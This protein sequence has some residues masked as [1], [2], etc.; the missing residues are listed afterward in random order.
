[1]ATPQGGTVVG[2]SATISQAPGTTTITQTSQRAAIDWQSFNLGSKARV[3][4][5]QPNAQAIALNRV[6]ANN[7]SIIAGR[8]DANGRIVLVNQDGVVFTPGSE[9]NAES[10]V[11]S[12][13][14]IS[15]KNFMAGKL[16]FDQQPKPG[17]RIVNDGRITMKQAGLAA[18]VAPEVINRG[19]ITAQLGHVVLAG[20]SAFTLNL[21]GDGL[22]SINVTQAV[23]QIDLGGRKVTALVTNEGT[24]IA[25]GG[26]ITLTARAVDGL[27]QQLLDVGGTLR[28]DSVGRQPGA[29]TIQGVGG[30][31]Q[32]AGQLLARGETPGSSGGTIAVDATGN[33]SVASTA[34]IDASGP[35]GGGVVALGTDA[36]RALQGPSDTTAPKAARVA[37][38]QGAT[39]SADAT[40]NGN[41]G[42]ITVLSRDRTTAAGTIS[43]QG[44]GNGDGGL[45]EIS[46]DGVISLSGTD[47]TFAPS[48][49]NG[50]ILLDPQ[51]LIVTSSSGTPSAG[52]T[53]TSGTLTVGTDSSTS[54]YID[55]S[56]LDSQ[57]G[58]VE[59]SA[60][61][62]ISIVSAISSSSIST[63]AMN[64]GGDI[65][66]AAPV[67]LT[68][69]SIEATANGTIEV[70]GALGASSISLLDT[71]SSPTNKIDINANIDAPTLSLDAGS[72]TIANA[73]SGYVTASTLDAAA[74]LVALTGSNSITTLG[75][76]N[77]G[78][79]T[80]DDNAPLTIAG[81]FNATDASITD[82][83]SL[84]IASAVSAIGSLGL[85][86]SDIGINASLDATTLS[87]DA[88]SGTIA[89]AGSGYVTAS[90]LDAAAS[91]VALTGSNSIT[92]LGSVN[93][94]NLTLDDNAPLT[95]AGSFNATDASITDTGSLD[96]ASAVSAIGSL[97]LSAS[98]IGINASLDA[99]TLSLDAKGGTITNAGS[100]SG[101]V[102]GY[103]TASTLDA[104]ASLVA[105]TGSNSI[106]T[107]GSVNVGTLTLD[108]NAPLTIAGSFTATSASLTDTGSL[109]ITGSFNATAA[110][111]AAPDIRINANIDAQTLSLDASGGTISNAGSV[112][113]YVTASVLDATASVLTLAGTGSSSLNNSI[114][115]LGSINV[116]S[117]AL[118]DEAALTIAAPFNATVASL[119]APDI[120]INASLDAQTLSLDASGG[121]ISNAGSGSVSGYVTA[122]TL[123]ATASVLTLAG[124]GSSSLNNSIDTLGS[125][126][127][128]S[129]ALDDETALTIAAPFNVTVASLAAPDI[130]INANIDAQTLSLDASG[131]TISNAGS[132][133]GYVTASTL[134]ATASVLTLVGTGNSSLNNAITTLGS[135]NVGSLALDDETALTI[136]APF[137]ATVASL[138]AP[139]IR[140]N[141]NIDAQTL[142]LD[143]SGGT[144][145]NAG[146]VSGYVTASVLDA[147]ASVLTLAG[148]G[149]SSLNNAIATLG[150]INV[151]S[152]AL[153]DETALTI[154][155]PFNATVASLAAPD[156][157]INANIDA[158]T[159]SLDASGGTISNAGSVSGYVTAS[160]LDATA[161]VLTLAGTGSSSLNNA[162]DTLGSINVGSLAL[163]DETALT[164]AGTVSVATHGQVA[165]I[166]RGLDDT[167]GATFLAPDGTIE[168]APLG[169][170]TIAGIL[171]L[172]GTSAGNVNV[173]TNFVT[174]LADSGAALLDLGTA[175][176]GPGTLAGGVI[177][178]GN[179]P[180]F[181][182]TLMVEASG[183]IVNDGLL[184]VGNITVM[185]S[186]F[187]GSGAVTADSLAGSV[188][189]F[190]SLQNRGNSIKVITSLSAGSSID[191]ADSQPL[192]IAGTLSV[193][194]GG[195]IVLSANGMD[196]AGGTILAN[197]GA[198]TLAPLGFD[199]IALGGTSTTALDL[200]NQLLNA[201][202]A[203]SLQIGTVQTG[204]IENDGSISLSIPNI[205]MDA[206]TIN[207]NQPFLA[208]HSSLIVQAGGE[209]TGNGGITVAALGAAASLV[210]LTGSNAITTLGSIS[211]GSFTLDDNAPLTIAGPFTATNASITN[212]GSLDITGSFNATDASL[213]AS[214]IRINANLDATT[215]SLD[216]N[217]GTI[218]NAGSGSVSGY[219][220]A[221]N[222]DATAS[223]VAL[224]GSNSITTLGSI[225]AGSFTLDDNAPLT[226]A[227]SF[228]AT[229]ASLS[230]SD[231]RINAN[232]D[233]TTLSLDANG[234]TITNAGS[235]SGYVTA[236]NLDATAS[237]VALTG[238]NS[239]TT[240]GS[241]NVGNLT[242]DDNAPLTIA[243]SFNATDA[244]IT[245]TGSL[246]IA[247]AV[248]AIG[249]LGLSASDIGIN[250]SLDATTLSLDAK[251]GT[252]TNA[253]SG[254]V[255]G[256]V[257]AS[258]LDATA[259]LVALTGSNAITTL[260]S[261]SAGSF[262][263]D[264]NAPLTIAGSFNAT[265][266]SLAASDIRINANLDAT[267]LSLDANGGT[268]TNAGSVSGY[269]TASNLDATAS[270]V[271]LT[272]SNA[273]TTLGSISAGSFTL[274]DN[275]P[276]T[277]TGSFNAT[278][279][280]LSASDI[281]INANLDATT[282]SL[283]A[284]A[285][286]IANAGSG[287][288]NATTLDAVASLVALTGS[289][290]ITTLGNVSAG[291]FTL[292]D[293]V[294]LTVAGPF[295]ATSASLTDTSAG[296]F[297]IAGQVSLASFLALSATSGS[298]TSSGTGSI[299]APTL[300][301]AAS[302]V[303]LTGSN[304]VTTLGSINVGTLTLDDE[305]AA[306]T[307]AG[308][309]NVTDARLTDTGSLDIASAVSAIGSLGLAASNIGINASLD[310]TIL[311]L[312][313]GSGTIANAG[314]G[315]VNATTLDA[316]AS[317][318]AL[319]GSNAITTLGSINVGN[320]TL[321]DNAPLTIAG[322]FNATSASLTDTSAGG[323]DIAGQVS[324]ASLLALSATG[325]SITSSGTGSISA[326]TLDATASL[327]ALTG[328]NSITTLGSINVGSF[329]LDDN[330]PLTIAGPFT[331][332][333]ASLTDTSAG[334][335]D[336]AAQVSL[337]S[338][339]ALS[340]TS[341]SITS[342]GTG[343]I[344][345]PTLDAAA[346]LVALTG[347]NSITTLGSINV[348]TLTLDDEAAALTIAG[349]LVAQ[350]AA[351]SA[352]DLTIPGVILVDGAL[353]LATS[354]TISE[355]GTIDPT[356]LQIAGARDVLLTGSNTI[357]ALGSVSVPLGNLALVDQVPLTVNGPVYAL[358]ISLDSPAMYIP[359]AINTPGTLGLGY[360]PIS[361]NGPIT[362]AT[363]TSNSAV[364]G[365]V[366]L[367][368]TENV[369]GTL[370]GFDAAGHLFALTDAT[371]LTV[372][373]PVSAKAL[374]ITATGQITLDGADGGSFAI[375]GQFL[376]TYVYNGLS[377]RNGID[378]VLQVI[379]N[380]APANGIVQTGQF[381]IDT[382]PLQGQPN[383]L[384][385]LLPDGA[386]AK[387]NDL[388]A[389]STDLAISLINGYAQGTLYLHYLLVAGGLNGQTAF[390][391]QIAGL[392]GSAAAH[393][394]KVVPVPGSSYRFNSCIIGS[395]SCTVLPVAIVPE[396]NPL[397]DFDI[398]PRRRRKLDANV[399]LPGVAAKDY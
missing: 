143:A 126:N 141:A 304:A 65:R 220:N 313:A 341:G 384:F 47:T 306:L 324:L 74:S 105:L 362:A 128:G 86:A 199:T 379:A 38:A 266:A 234:G 363:L 375:G 233:A 83:G 61:S 78:N 138:A 206:G 179:L 323:F 349:S 53:T 256:Y 156:I 230:A 211:A 342:S 368:G 389:R 248:S 219:V 344:S 279:A 195:N 200:S 135:I 108:D 187:S 377:P 56:I 277:I 91:L 333:N 328:S 180:S 227:G 365:D 274:D 272:G 395:V 249:S 186:D 374:T 145:S 63:L 263:L 380:G 7:P 325:G 348:G 189:G 92:T 60:S 245:D 358:N 106:T 198:V 116:G 48:G 246:D 26:R 66:I 292:D 177:F 4:F 17:A 18:F 305:A 125:I 112:S 391:G 330:A 147:T 334:G 295:T 273:I 310:A 309:F 70:S 207:I 2:G 190:A 350:R 99:T 122:S 174:L 366:A 257:T 72:G 22:I 114:D 290:A 163:D 308:P 113:G 232:L 117:L 152:L 178:D 373:G 36:A 71:A 314:S 21:S 154:A 300:D 223:L 119:A 288:V 41:G 393:N 42:R 255:S 159:L 296:G 385:M 326:P 280:S 146:S 40:R 303:A 155:A 269:V 275:A 162:I 109:D 103:V 388:N 376:P 6:I 238:S 268:I 182:P 361:G 104:T 15:P 236:S 57:T 343:S 339:L 54:S 209:F 231:I 170:S 258:V 244:S 259:S 302:L 299:S 251:G 340:A 80:L 44:A 171:D 62:L 134:D 392:A 271:A 381:N 318:V 196:L 164:I 378:S 45:I 46:S 262:T 398:S 194:S 167:S 281:G 228:N 301:A 386:D 29:I 250:A 319:T 14:G 215:L 217:G 124:T 353:S 84:D 67:T 96:I 371:A 150:S 352:A 291:S 131:G 320:F 289:N 285:G 372:A 382:G 264:D 165:F 8:I 168:I 222:L 317:L 49:R 218:T 19:T 387:F 132:V 203:N 226:I 225:S 369:I 397:D 390:V 253:A 166:T 100:G 278:D 354:G 298:I 35:A 192:T 11:V 169:S 102:S 345:A 243:G 158:P 327:V 121:T 261:I 221:S 337:A 16:I 123:D 193:A 32:V 73:G 5:N 97:G 183:S 175:N 13:S 260:G 383:T 338:L 95:I 33:V 208:Q 205:L 31:L 254:S 133:S 356:L 50:T 201:I 37:I 214:D 160:T 229:D 34:R 311:S 90:T 287:Y 252:I 12:T 142:S 293:N 360:G 240:L 157:R 224:T 307:I 9:V 202:S 148:T 30:D 191:V 144:I 20:A 140:I 51:T 357:D 98:D 76:V 87:L 399:R 149:S 235:V 332:T 210:A 185:G 107:L 129:L 85:S 322:P 139:D 81:S 265:S 136:A 77:V 286:T 10:L 88:G 184:S 216:A 329:T 120:R 204:L 69:G 315:Y 110:S 197:S 115:T 242:L 118:N 394:G 52:T 316:A 137:N 267:T 294:P 43:A 270:L 68:A 59:L 82:T 25:N 359:G 93:V 27:I 172:G 23:R 55:A 321:D 58:A 188:S 130:R 282:L 28:A 351:I 364:I 247:S 355:T 89:N 173:S 3:T 24:I 64:S 181:T 312:D 213:A 241:V 153:D 75:S 283:D 284:N 396:R 346:S 367:T 39:I 297:D 331:A 336:I 276:L 101:S 347:S 239:I 94:G 161:S 176:A 127:V 212:T 151:G 79:L 1:M 335:F 111:L 237:L 370:G